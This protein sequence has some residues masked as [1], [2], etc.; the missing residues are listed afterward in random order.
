MLNGL[1]NICNGP[2]PQIPSE[3]CHCKQGYVRLTTYSGCQATTTC[4]G[5]EINLLNKDISATK[6]FFL[7]CGE[8]AYYN[9]NGPN[10]NATCDNHLIY[11]QLN[12][13]YSTPGCQCQ[14]RF[15]YDEIISQCVLPN[16]CPTNPQCPKNEVYQTNGND[17]D[18]YQYYGGYSGLSNQPGCYCKSGYVRDST[19]LCV[20]VSECG[21]EFIKNENS[22]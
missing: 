10:I 22:T 7:E 13:T 17:I 2:V 11:F 14:N 1:D 9:E 16:N 20:P 8:N 21:C 5:K 3:G 15:V 4:N 12:K 19:G 18:C 6:P